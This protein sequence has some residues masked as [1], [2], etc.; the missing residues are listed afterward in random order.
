MNSGSF[1]LSCE[2]PIF[3]V[4]RTLFLFHCTARPR[5]QWAFLPFP[6]FSNM[7][8]STTS[9]AKDEYVLTTGD[10]AGGTWLVGTI[11]L[12]PAAVIRCFGKGGCADKCKVSR[13][14][15]FCKGDLI[16]TLYDWK[17]TDLYDPALM[18]PE[19]FWSMKLPMELHI[20]SNASSAPADIQH[21]AEW[22]TSKMSNVKK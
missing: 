19:Q 11:F 13:E 21:F 6:I 5:T 22:I 8:T 3:R 2:H 16:F 15:V 10:Q 1:S 12:P 17:S 7:E 4:P 18:T 20:G 9:S 14:Y